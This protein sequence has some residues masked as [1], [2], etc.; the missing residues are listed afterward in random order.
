METI[1]IRVKYIKEDNTPVPLVNFIDAATRVLEFLQSVGDDVGLKL[2]EGKWSAS[3]FRSSAPAYDLEQDISDGKSEDYCLMLENI[4]EYK[5]GKEVLGRVVNLETYKKY[6][7]IAQPIRF[8]ERVA[9][10]I[11]RKPRDKAPTKWHDLDKEGAESEIAKIKEYEASKPKE[12]RELHSEIQG[13]IWN[14]HKE[15][16]KPYIEVRDIN[17]GT[18]IKC[19]YDNKIYQ[20]IFELFDHKENLVFVEGDM[21]ISPGEV[22]ALSIQ[23]I[24][25]RVNEYAKCHREGDLNKFFGCA[26]GLTGNLTAREYIERIRD[27]D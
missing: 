8:R 18:M 5:W 4:M 27:E 10:G 26:P 11:Y 16:D 9:L 6:L 2:D 17:T 12:K 7:A 25:P 23:N 24:K 15:G 20:S 22:G 14:W 13:K 21:T 19:Y 3:R 1:R